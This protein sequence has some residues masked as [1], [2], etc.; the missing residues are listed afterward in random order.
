MFD[1]PTVWVPATLK[2]N[3][4]HWKITF[5]PL[6][7]LLFCFAHIEMHLS[8]LIFQNWQ[9]VVQIQHIRKRVDFEA[10]EH[11]FFAIHFFL[12]HGQHIHLK[13]KMSVI[14]LYATDLHLISIW[15]K[16]NNIFQCSCLEVS[17]Y[18][19]NCYW[20]GFKFVIKGI[21]CKWNTCLT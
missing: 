16:C 20:N 9:T 5:Q 17:F 11:F 18:V 4:D 14:T 13:V 2:K 21:F 12:F 6:S 19:L 3:F 1:F 8:I 7:I 10:L 15:P